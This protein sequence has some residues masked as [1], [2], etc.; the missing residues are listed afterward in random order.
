M[1]R[2]IALGLAMAASSLHVQWHHSTSIGT[3][4]P[5]RLHHGVRLPAGS[6]A[7]LTWDPVLGARRTAPGAAGAP[8]GSCASS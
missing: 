6:R 7:F 1:A 5:A 4:P 2:Q 8:I 3:P